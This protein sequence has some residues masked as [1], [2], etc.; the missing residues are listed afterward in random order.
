MRVHVHQFATEAAA[1]AIADGVNLYSTDGV[2]ACWQERQEG[3]DFCVAI[4]DCRPMGT[5]GAV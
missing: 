4:H 2:A 3:P 5:D 1:V